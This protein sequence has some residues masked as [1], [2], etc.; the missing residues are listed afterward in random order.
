MACS[1]SKAFLLSGG[2]SPSLAPT[3]RHGFLRRRARHR[4]R[5]SDPARTGLRIHLPGLLP[6]WA[7]RI[8]GLAAYQSAKWAISGFSTVLAQ[9]L[10][11]LG[12]KVTALEPGGMR[13]DWAGSSMTI[14]PISEPYQQTIGQ[15]AML[16]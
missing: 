6:R 11:P 7:P 1:G 2:A 15:F 5:R 8:T 14:P 3:G 4:G 10:A 13:T 16:R 12:I 9:E